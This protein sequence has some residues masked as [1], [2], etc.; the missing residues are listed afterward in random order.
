MAS[1]ETSDSLRSTPSK[2]EKLLKSP[3]KSF[4][5][6]STDSDSLQSTPRKSKTPL[7][8]ASKLHS[9]PPL[10]KTPDKQPPAFSNRARNRGVALSTKD[11]RKIAQIRP[12]RKQTSPSPSESLAPIISDCAPT[13]P[14]KKSGNASIKLPQSHEMLCEFFN[15]L[16]SAIRLSRMKGLMSNFATISPQVQRLTDRRFSCGH[17][18]QLKHILPEAIEI[19]RVQMFDERTS[20]MKPDLHITINPDAIEFEAKSKS[21]SKNPNLRK[22]FRTRIEDFYKAHPQGEEIP[23][24]DL[25]EPFSHSKQTLDLN[26]N[27]AS[28]SST[29]VLATFTL[30]DRQ[31]TFST[32][33]DAD[34]DE[35]EPHPSNHLAIQTTKTSSLSLAIKKSTDADNG[36]PS[37]A[38]SH[39]SQSFRKHFSQKV[40]G[41]EGCFSLQP[42]SP[43]DAEPCC[44]KISSNKETSSASE[45]STIKLSSKA[46]NSENPTHLTLNHP[47]S[48]PV[49]GIELIKGEDGSPSE[50]GTIQST[51]AKPASTPAGP[52]TATPG[53]QP[54]KRCY[55]SPDDVST[56]LPNKL[57]RRPPPSR[58]LKFDT[59]V[60]NKVDKV[61]ELVDDSIDDDVH[62]ILPVSLLQSIREKERK[63]MEERDPAISQAKRRRQMIASLPKLFNMIH[64]LF[65]SIQRSVITKEE[66]VNKITTGHSAI[67]DKI[68]VEEQLEL[69]LE[70]VPE[71]I[72]EKLASSGDL[73]VCINKMSSPES[74]RLKLQ[75]A[76]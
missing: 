49:K 7:N 14:P 16:D 21:E 43:R 33:G 12:T 11:I 23:K 40:R 13:P 52:N 22:I 26:V 27:K 45:P 66:L 62:S 6:P 65:Q 36:Q 59:P 76:N 29:S 53:L 70:L 41:K 19:K 2:C 8:P 46:T 64:Y 48:T 3:S 10:S 75:E 24:E 74:I 60:K 55:M 57:V 47:L 54:P 32:E 39:I 20:C 72:S 1:S 61:H 56:A 34:E 4:S 73:L 38:A 63:A 9:P 35:I 31:Q 28:S 30:T 37:V 25:P 50:V 58:S 18:A 69:L 51:P 5:S 44:E 15:S 68:E 67:V 42:S 71:W 17:L